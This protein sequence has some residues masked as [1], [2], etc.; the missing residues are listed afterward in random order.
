[1]H[2]PTDRIP[3]DVVADALRASL[4]IDAAA[5]LG[6]ARAAVDALSGAD[7]LGVL[8]AVLELCD[9]DVEGAA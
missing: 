7:A 6:D 3:D 1:M 8:R 2:V 5:P 9:V 4:N